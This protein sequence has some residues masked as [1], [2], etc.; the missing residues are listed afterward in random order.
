MPDLPS[1][2]SAVVS[3][4]NGHLWVGTNH[5]LY[6]LNATPPTPIPTPSI[7]ETVAN[8]DFVFSSPNDVNTSVNSMVPVTEVEGPIISLAWRG[9]LMGPKGW[10]LQGKAFLLINSSEQYWQD[11]SFSSGTDY[12]RGTMNALDDFGLL[13]IGTP[14][15]LYFYDGN[16]FWF[17]WV[18]DWENGIGGVV[19]GS[20]VSMTFVPS[21]ELFIG[22]NISL[23]RLNID[24]TFDRFG[25]AEGLPYS[26]ILS[27]RYSPFSPKA[28]SPLKPKSTTLSS[29][30]MLWIG[31]EKGWNLLDVHNSEFIG[32]FYGPRWHSGSSIVSIAGVDIDEMIVL[33]TDEGMTVVSA[34]QWT[35]EKKALH[36]QEILR[37]HVREP[38]NTT[39][40][41]TLKDVFFCDLPIA[42][43]MRPFII[44]GTTKDTVL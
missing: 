32:Y 22:N 26:H 36:Y 2:S 29:Q 25:G 10:G 11:V 24:Y 34:E 33:L 35:L 39:C 44:V 21:G 27:L 43:V 1:I 28:P 23:S 14:T 9:G 8:D 38:G 37:R 17:E 19:D 15:K 16:M 5:G 42:C 40:T 20:P 30:G 6:R 12:Y 4:S 41:C 18:S 3:E 7:M 31:T 13:V